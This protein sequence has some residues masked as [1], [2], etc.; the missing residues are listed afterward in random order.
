MWLN[1]AFLLVI[2]VTIYCI[3]SYRFVIYKLPRYKIG[4]VGS[5]V[6]YMYLDSSVG[7]WQMSQFMVNTSQGAI[8]NTLNQ[9]YKGQ[10]YKV[11]G[12]SNMLFEQSTMVS[13]HLEF[14][15]YWQPRL[16]ANWGQAH[17][18]LMN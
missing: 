1:Y 2:D 9:L 8:A 15:T 7:S 17:H 12:K 11:G 4:T 13:F 10:A 18:S 14:A 5:G 6:D 3:L 16:S